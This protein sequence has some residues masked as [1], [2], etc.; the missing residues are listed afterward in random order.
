MTQCVIRCCVPDC[1]AK[2]LANEPRH[3]TSKHS[4]RAG[5]H[6]PNTLQ[7]ST[8]S[9]RRHRSGAAAPGRRQPSRP[10][11]ALQ[12]GYQ[13]LRQTALASA[14]RQQR[15]GQ[16]ECGAAAAAV[17]STAEQVSQWVSDSKLQRLQGLEVRRN[18]AAAPSVRS[19]GCSSEQTGIQSAPQRIAAASTRCDASRPLW[20]RN[21]LLGR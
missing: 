14:R 3:I 5:L 21:C 19:Q 17:A 18:T 20:F 11:P 16:R 15:R 6:H 2:R 10:Q 7:T 12:R 9:P 1:T 8:A 4:C 13:Q